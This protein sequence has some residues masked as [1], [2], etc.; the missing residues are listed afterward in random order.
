MKYNPDFHHRRSIRLKDYDYTQKGHCF[1]TICCQNRLRLFGNVQYKKMCLNNAGDMIHRW[2]NCLE[3][4]FQ[5]IVCHE[6][7]VM[8]D[9]V[10]FI[11]QTVG[12]DQS[13]DPTSLPKIIQWFKTMTTNEYIKGVKTKKWPRFQKRLWQRNYYEHIIKDDRALKNITQYIIDNP[14]NY[15]P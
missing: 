1:I 11:I 2:Y 13:V 7:M 9:H 12:V 6:I 5:D 10:H 4:K 8:P 14:K 15:H 3:S